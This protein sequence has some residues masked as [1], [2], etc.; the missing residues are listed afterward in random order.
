MQ[1]RH[2]IPNRIDHIAMKVILLPKFDQPVTKSLAEDRV[3]RMMFLDVAARAAC[4]DGIVKVLMCQDGRDKKADAAQTAEAAYMTRFFMDNV[5]PP[6]RVNFKDFSFLGNTMS[7]EMFMQ[8]H[9]FFFCGFS[10]VLREPN[11]ANLL[12]H[13]C[14]ARYK[15]ADRLKQTVFK[16]TLLYIGVCGGAIVAGETWRPNRQLPGATGILAG[17]NVKYDSGSSPDEVG[18]PLTS[19]QVLHLTSWSG[20]AMW[21]DPDENMSSSFVTSKNGRHS[22]KKRAWVDQNAQRLHASM[23]GL[24]AWRAVPWGFL[25][26]DGWMWVKPNGPIIRFDQG[27]R[28]YEVQP[29]PNRAAAPFS[30]S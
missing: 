24:C 12:E 16:G 9:V 6:V 10:A 14:P 15:A 2:I 8:A 22:G 19:A 25:R 27:R 4:D 13:T 11:L 17:A 23:T 1:I 28:Y 29:P 26:P 7:D 5:H 21:C 30:E 3:S 20:L 18:C